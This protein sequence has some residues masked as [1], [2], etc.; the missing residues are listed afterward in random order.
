MTGL[1]IEEILD[2]LDLRG[3]RLE[4]WPAQD[5]AAAEALLDSSSE[6]RGHLAAMRRVESA[7]AQTQPAANTNIDSIAARAMR[8]AQDTSRRVAMRRVSWAF[9][10]SLALFAGLYVGAQPEPNDAPA[11]MVVAALGQSGDHD[12]W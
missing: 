7:L 3:G 2:E 9:A 11:D 10:G 12:A 8:S 1:H 5:R 6:A 4:N